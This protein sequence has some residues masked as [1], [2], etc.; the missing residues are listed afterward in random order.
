MA[1]R[2]HQVIGYFRRHLNPW[3]QYDSI[4]GVFVIFS[5]KWNCYIYITM[6]HFQNVSGTGS[7]IL[8]GMYNDEKPD[9]VEGHTSSGYGHTKGKV[10]QVFTDLY[11]LYSRQY[12]YVF[13]TVVNLYMDDELRL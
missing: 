9:S 8:Y 1:F 5:N 11:I 10:Q 13:W 4:C 6:G 2:F 3:R 12:K 7:N